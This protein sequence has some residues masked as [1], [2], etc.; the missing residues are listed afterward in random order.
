[1]WCQQYVLLIG[2]PGKADFLPALNLAQGGFQEHLPSP[3]SSLRSQASRRAPPF[4][5]DAPYPESPPT[6][7]GPGA[8]PPEPLLT[9]GIPDLELDA[10]A[11]LDLNQTGEKIHPH[12]GVRNLGEAALGEAADQTGLAHRGIP[13]DNEPKLVQPDGL[14]GWARRS[15]GARGLGLG[16]DGAPPRRPRRRRGARALERPR[17]HRWPRSPRRGRPRRRASERRMEAPRS[18]APSQR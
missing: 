4:P 16:G 3:R 15:P 2:L 8:R 12:R 18:L 6:A 7:W 11:W 17:E 9:R 13:D 10:F 1:M 14:H 5:R